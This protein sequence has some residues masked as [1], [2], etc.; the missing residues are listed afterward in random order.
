MSRNRRAVL[1]SILP[2]MLLVSSL[3]LAASAVEVD[4]TWTGTM[5][6]GDEERKL[7]LILET[8]GTRLDG[9]YIIHPD[10]ANE[11]LRR[12]GLQRVVGRRM[13]VDDMPHLPIRNGKVD[14]EVIM[15]DVE[16]PGVLVHFELVAVRDASGDMLV[17]TLRRTPKHSRP[18]ARE[19]D[20]RLA[21]G[22]VRLRR[23][24]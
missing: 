6:S 7:I 13:T 22:R 21:T 5:Y 24:E 8:S 20:E 9:T 4:G 14:D 15:F 19:H 16:T 2:T 23:E 1:R 12:F 18:Y 10:D 3:P 17:G 11:A